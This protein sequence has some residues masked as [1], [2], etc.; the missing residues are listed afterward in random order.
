M[1]EAARFE[2]LHV[3]P[4]LSQRND[5]LINQWLKSGRLD[6]LEQDVNCFTGLVNGV[7]AVIGG[8]YTFW[9]GRGYL[10]SIFNEDFKSNFVPVFRGLKR[11]LSDLPFCRLEMAIATSCPEYANAVRRAG[12]LGFKLEVPRAEQYLPEAGDASI[13]V[14]IKHVI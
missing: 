5:T 2:K 4:F 10:W 14:R 1:F 6:A 8:V 9:Q 13:L 11:F 7:P 12:L 3:L